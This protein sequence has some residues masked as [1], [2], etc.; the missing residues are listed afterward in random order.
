MTR[1]RDA[2]GGKQFF[3][4]G[5]TGFLGTA[6]VER[7][8][9][10]VPDSRVVLLI[11]PGRRST[12]GQRAA[13]EILR[14]DC[15]DRLRQQHGERFET[16]VA[17]RVVAVAGDVTTDGLG[18]DEEGM[19]LL[20]EC[21]IVVHSAAAVSFDSPL[22]T[23]VEVNLLGPSRVAAAVAEARQLASEHGRRGPVHYLPV[24]TAYV[25]GSHQGEAREDL[26]DGNPFT[27]NV[28]WRTEVAAA[29]RQRGDLDA[30]SRRPQR[31]ASFSKEARG[32]V[33]G[34]RTPPPRREGRAA[35]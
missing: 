18:L 26:L 30:E 9:R 13:K 10:T 2:L 23:A 8:L 1:V 21:D 7:L 12:P 19:Q 20:S 24:S 35:P 6:L 14:N 31:L 29:R 16:E 22:D 25:A 27:V 28:D 5:A 32:R 4:T 11:R 3:V 34:R 17:A 15:F 33:G